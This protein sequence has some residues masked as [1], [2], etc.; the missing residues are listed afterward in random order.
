[1]TGVRCLL[2]NNIRLSVLVRKGLRPLLLALIVATLYGIQHYDPGKVYSN[3]QGRVWNAWQDWGVDFFETKPLV[4][5]IQIDAGSIN[6]LSDAQDGEDWPWSRQR[7]VELLRILFEKYGVQVVGIDLYFSDTRD[8]AGNE[9]LMALAKEHRIVFAQVFDLEN[10]PEEAFSS[11]EL[12]GGIRKQD[13]AAFNLFPQASGYVANNSQLADA[14]CVGHITPVKDANGV[15]T[16]VPP[17]VVWKD[18]FYPMLALEMLRCLNDDDGQYDFSVVEG[19]NG[20]QLELQDFPFE[21][22]SM[23]LDVDDNGS[24]RVPYRF[25]RERSDGVPVIYGVPAIDVLKGEVENPE[26]VFRSG[27]VLLAGTAAGLG[28][29]HATPLERITPGVSV[30]VQLFDWL[31]WLLQNGDNAPPFSLEKWSWVVALGCLLV[32]YL[33]LARGVSAAVITVLAVSLMTA[34]LVLGFWAWVDRQWFLPVFPALLLLLFLM[35]QVPMEWWMAQRTSGRLRTLFQ[36]YLPAPL[37]EHIVNENRA[38]L[39]QPSRRCLTILFADIA[40]FTR[41]AEHSTPEEL[42]ELTRQILESLTAVAHK[43][44]GTVDKYM[45]DAVLIFWNAPFDQPDHADKGMQ[46][47]LEMMAAIRDF[48]KEQQDLLKGEPIAVRIGLH[49][50]D[51]VV[52]DLGTRFRHAYTAIGDA[53]NVAARLQALARELKESLVIS[54]QTVTLLKKQYA[55]TS[56]GSSGLKGRQEAVGIYALAPDE[57]QE[58]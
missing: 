48:N 23:R 20:W 53:V 38:D 11:G 39:L 35:L 32:L 43:Y 57:Q 24:L 14:K 41:R 21:G 6:Q 12:M 31:I 16:H 34:W 36:D 46:A 44:G 19:A 2:E 15:V 8:V 50:G 29:Q 1:M 28:D 10:A 26:E 22:A 45:G 25:P 51:V 13:E 49:S 47:A 30:H 4:T 33:L 17:L 52:G 56:K 40:D 27:V 5:V 3:F 55:L 58:T 54:E 42:S 7:Y 37:V 18:R 9:A